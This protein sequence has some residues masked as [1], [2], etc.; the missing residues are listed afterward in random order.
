MDKNTKQE[1]VDMLKEARGTP[2]EWDI[3]M[4]MV[5]MLEDEEEFEHMAQVYRGIAEYNGEFLTEKEAHRIVSEF[6]NFDGTRGA[7]WQPEVLF[8]AVE[9]LGGK[10]SEPGKYNCWALF[11]QMNRKHSD[12]GGVLASYAHDG[13]YAKLCYMLSVAVLTDRDKKETL[14]Q[15]YRLQK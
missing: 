1:F 7:K 14:R 4:E 8:S 3:I 15:Y 13:E 6:I 12:E 10:R 5:D 2:Q 9:S 11:V